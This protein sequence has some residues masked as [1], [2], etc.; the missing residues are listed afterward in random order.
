MRDRGKE[1]FDFNVP[2]TVQGHLRTNRDRERERRE[3]ERERARETE[4][5]T[6][7]QRR[8][9]RE[10]EKERESERERQRD[11]GERERGE[12]RAFTLAALM[13]YCLW[14]KISILTTGLK[15]LSLNHIHAAIT[16]ILVS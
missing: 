7:R 13:L 8:G 10:R 2:S 15:T 5:E 12:R 3:R 16:V 11:R 9:E 6:E 1:F 14:H 4:R